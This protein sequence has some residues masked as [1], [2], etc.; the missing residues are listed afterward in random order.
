MKKKSERMKA[1]SIRLPEKLG[2]KVEML[3][4]KEHRS[5]NQTVVY[6]LEWAL[7]ELQ[8]RQGHDRSHGQINGR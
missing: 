8:A 3:A 5:L 4:K 2:M 6:Y 1:L 7:E